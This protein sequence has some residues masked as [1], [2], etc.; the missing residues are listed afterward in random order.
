MTQRT[1]FEA[2]GISQMT[3][4]RYVGSRHNWS[5]TFD[6]QRCKKMEGMLAMK[7][8]VLVFFIG[9]VVGLADLVGGEAG[10]WSGW[11]FGLF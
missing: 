10:W 8:W 11:Y 9:F 5:P 7:F 4:A 2:M 3:A 6:Q 1:P